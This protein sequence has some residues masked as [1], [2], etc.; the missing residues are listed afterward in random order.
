M[1]GYRVEACRVGMTEDDQGLHATDCPGSSV[2]DQELVSGR[3]NG[4]GE[5]ALRHCKKALELEPDF[6]A[7]KTLLEGLADN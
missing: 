7:A 5:S 3:A 2:P 1:R 6:E 4:D